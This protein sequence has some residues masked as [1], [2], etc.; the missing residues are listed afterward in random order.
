MFDTGE[1]YIKRDLFDS[2]EEPPPT[3]LPPPNRVFGDTPP[4]QPAKSR[5]ES[6]CPFSAKVMLL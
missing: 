6:F 5:F 4:G 3:R 2:G 1:K